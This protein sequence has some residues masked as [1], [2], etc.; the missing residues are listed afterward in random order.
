MQIAEAAR[1]SLLALCGMVVLVLVFV[2]TGWK[3]S[4]LEGGVLVLIALA[5][6]VVDFASQSP[7]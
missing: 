3:V 4:R 6:W 1:M 2:R 5:R 7:Q